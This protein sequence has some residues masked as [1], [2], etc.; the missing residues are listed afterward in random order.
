[1]SSEKTP[2]SPEFKRCIV[3]FYRE[4][5]KSA[6]DTHSDMVAVYGDQAPG[7]AIIYRWRDKYA[8]EW[9][10]LSSSLGA[11]VTKSFQYAC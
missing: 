3:W 2:L 7:M 1:M 6:A 10:D 4:L 5:G 9:P 11:H 8:D